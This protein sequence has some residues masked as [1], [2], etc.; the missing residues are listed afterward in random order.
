MPTAPVIPIRNYA[1]GDETARVTVMVN[2]E[3]GCVLTEESVECQFDN[4]EVRVVNWRNTG[5]F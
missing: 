4:N 2:F 3:P 1:W 5:L